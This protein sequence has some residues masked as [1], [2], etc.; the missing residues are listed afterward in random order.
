L[1][2]FNECAGLA[3]IMDPDAA[4]F[5]PHQVLDGDRV[6]IALVLDEQLVLRFV[7]EGADSVAAEAGTSDQMAL[8]ARREADTRDR[9]IRTRPTHPAS[10]SSRRSHFHSS[11]VM[12]SSQL[13]YAIAALLNS[14]SIRPYSRTAIST[15]VRHSVR[16]VRWHG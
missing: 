3:M 13:K 1:S 11:S 9:M 15:S 8:L 12:S 2:R 7:D 14:T 10:T 16:S 6:L 5:R 4:T